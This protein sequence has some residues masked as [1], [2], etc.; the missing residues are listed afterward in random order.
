MYRGG[1]GGGGGGGHPIM[2]RPT[3]VSWFKSDEKTGENKGCLLFAPKK[4]KQ[5]HN[6]VLQAKIQS[7][8]RITANHVFF[9]SEE[10]GVLKRL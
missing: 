1:G 6:H 5:S 7:D 10:G 8:I 3:S 4:K 2:H 9:L